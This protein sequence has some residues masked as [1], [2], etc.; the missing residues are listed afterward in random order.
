MEESM[1]VLLNGADEEMLREV[2]RCDDAQ[3]N[4]AGLIVIMQALGGNVLY[5]SLKRLG[6]I[7]YEEE[8]RRHPI[9]YLEFGK[10]LKCRNQQKG[11]FALWIR[12]GFDWTGNA[13]ISRLLDE[14]GEM[15]VLSNGD[16]VPLILIADVRKR[17]SLLSPIARKTLEIMCGG[18]NEK[19]IGSL[20]Q[21]QDLHF[22]CETGGIAPAVS[23]IVSEILNL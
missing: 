8:G 18:T 1:I 14:N 22:I 5:W 19:I 7:R 16:R 11:Q 13:L 4:R 20:Q 10:A 17:L 23:S 15:A 2:C 9:S 6:F 3:Q 12:V 21:L